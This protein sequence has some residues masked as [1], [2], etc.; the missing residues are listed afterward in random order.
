MES[1]EIAIRDESVFQLTDCVDT[2]N[3]ANT[4][5]PSALIKTVTRDIDEVIKQLLNM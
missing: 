3:I 2:L 4:I 5:E 1:N